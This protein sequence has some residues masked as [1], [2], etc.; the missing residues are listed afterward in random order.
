MKRAVAGVKGQGK[1]ATD[2]GRDFF[3]SEEL[4]MT[5]VRC[6]MMKKKILWWKKKC[7]CVTTESEAGS[8]S[9]WTVFLMNTCG[10][11]ALQDHT[12]CGFPLFPSF[13]NSCKWCGL[14][15]TSRQSRTDLIQE[16]FR[17]MLLC[18][19]VKGMRLGNYWREF[20]T[21]A[22]KLKAF[23]KEISSSLCSCTVIYGWGLRRRQG[24]VLRRC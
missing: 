6:L 12:E 1:Q 16:R 8:R 11:R 13:A 2:S 21:V 23:E 17:A 15:R 3:W 24:R 19:R 7:S 18:S 22:F 5:F 20:G 9:A 4:L 14:E 10:C